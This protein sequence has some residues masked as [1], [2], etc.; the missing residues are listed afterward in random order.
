[1]QLLEEG[2]FISKTNSGKT[3]KIFQGSRRLA[4]I[5]F[6]DIVGYTKLC[7]ENEILAL[8]LLEDHALLVRPIVQAHDGTEVKTIGDAFMIVFSSAMDAVLCAIQIQAHMGDRNARVSAKEQLHLRIGLHLG[9]VFKRAGDND[10]YGDGVNV[11]SRV[12]NLAPGDTIYFTQQIYDQIEKQIESPLIDM[13]LKN[14]K[15]VKEP[16]HVYKIGTQAE[17]D[18][19]QLTQAI[20]EEDMKTAFIDAQ[21]VLLD[22]R[23]GDERREEQVGHLPAPLIDRRRLNSRRE[24]PAATEPKKVLLNF[25]APQRSRVKPGYVESLSSRERFLLVL[26]AVTSLLGGF[27]FGVNHLPNNLLATAAKDMTDYGAV[28]R[29]ASEVAAPVPVNAAPDCAAAPQSCLNRAFVYEKSGTYPE[30]A[31]LYSAA[32]DAKLGKACLALSKMY[33]NGQGMAASSVMADGLLI[34]ACQTGEAEACGRLKG[35]LF[36]EKH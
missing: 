1:M 15:N 36:Q 9:D 27:S 11:A 32:C 20:S 3:G 14:V 17:A 12:V 31:A 5:M 2:G 4:A 6:T 18:G 33:S 7:Q 19:K 23:S 26:L 29:V 24:R 21:E 22:R 25:A 16:L 35:L 10:L 30:A 28:R 34:K 13:G 8:Q